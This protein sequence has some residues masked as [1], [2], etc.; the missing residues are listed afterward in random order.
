V[1]TEIADLAPPPGLGFPRF[2]LCVEKARPIPGTSLNPTL[3]GVAL[4]LSEHG[5]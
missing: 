1:L 2:P 5:V 3:Q 4:T